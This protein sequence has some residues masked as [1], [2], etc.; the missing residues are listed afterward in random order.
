VS[1]GELIRRAVSKAGAGDIVARLPAGYTTV[2]GTM[3]KSGTELSAGEWQRVALA[4]SYLRE[5]PILILDEPTSAM[6][7]WSEA[8]WLRQ[9]QELQR[10]RT[11]VIISHR[12][13]G[14]DACDHDPCRA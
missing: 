10:T 6:D 12:F 1:D 7:P 4:R 5:A 14:D 9:L 2:L 8:E 3:F 11:T 13:F